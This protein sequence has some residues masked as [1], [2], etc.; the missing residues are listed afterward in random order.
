[1]LMFNLNVL[2]VEFWDDICLE[3]VDDCVVVMWF[4]DGLFG[5]YVGRF[6][7]IVVGFVGCVGKSWM[8]MFSFLFFLIISL[9]KWLSV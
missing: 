9:L 2:E 5:G 1:M 6:L 8:L 7:L 4:D 3:C